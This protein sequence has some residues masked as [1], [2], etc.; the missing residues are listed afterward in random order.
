MAYEAWY[1]DDLST[2][3]TIPSSIVVQVPHFYESL[4]FCCHREKVYVSMTSNSNACPACWRFL[5]CP[6]IYWMRHQRTITM[7]EMRDM[8]KL[9]NGAA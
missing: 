8:D 4:C 1:G 9:V 2:F 7:N 3:S 5:S 6:T